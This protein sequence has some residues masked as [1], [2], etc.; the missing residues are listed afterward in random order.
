MFLKVIHRWRLLYPV[1]EKPHALKTAGD[2]IVGWQ[3]KLMVA[4]WVRYILM[5]E[6]QDAF[7]C[8]RRM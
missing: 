2:P 5:R 7:R 8:G 6:L 4:I 3:M 1:L